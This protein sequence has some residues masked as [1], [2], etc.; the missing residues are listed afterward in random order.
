MIYKFSLRRIASDKSG[1]YIN[2]WD[3]SVPVVVFAGTESEAIEKAKTLSGICESRREWKFQL[4]SIEECEN[5]AAK[6]TAQ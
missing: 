6:E 4:D 3:K 5:S 1:Y 2:R